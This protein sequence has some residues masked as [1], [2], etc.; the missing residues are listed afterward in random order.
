VLKTADR[1]DPPAL[2]A[3]WWAKC[4]PCRCVRTGFAAWNA[5]D[6]EEF[7]SLLNELLRGPTGDGIVEKRGLDQ[8]GIADRIGA[9]RL[10]SGRSELELANELGL[11]VDGYCD[12]EQQDSELESVLSIAQALKLAKLLGTNVLGLLGEAEQPLKVPIA[13]VRSALVAHLGSSAEAKE[14]MED[15]I[16]WDLGPFLEGTDEWT[17]V[18]TIEF[19]KKLAIAIEVDWQVVLAGISNG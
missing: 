16:D 3:A 15:E 14:A 19:I 18:Y 9:L 7:N 2:G 10:E 4:S 1:R 5:G 13:R 17:S 12:L 8:M 6:G 11:T